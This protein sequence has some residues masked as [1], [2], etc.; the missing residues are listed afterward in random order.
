M[1]IILVIILLKLHDEKGENKWLAELDLKDD[2][3]VTCALAKIHFF[4]IMMRDFSLFLSEV[5]TSPRARCS[6]TFSLHLSSILIDVLFFSFLLFYARKALYEEEAKIC[7]PSDTDCS[8]IK[9]L[10]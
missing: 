4:M 9:E 8:P 3:Y 7:D 6:L 2:L 1:S 10:L 5:S